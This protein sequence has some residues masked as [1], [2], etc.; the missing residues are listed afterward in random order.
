MKKESHWTGNKRSGPAVTWPY[1]LEKSFHLS[2]S[3]FVHPALSEDDEDYLFWNGFAKVKIAVR[4]L[5]VMEGTFSS[6]FGTVFPLS[7][8]R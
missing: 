1:N 6:V 2:E 4:H 3:Y 7:Q 5:C 8:C